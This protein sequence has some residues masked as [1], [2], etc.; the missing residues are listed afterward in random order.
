MQKVNFI[1]QL[2]LEIR[3]THHLSSL[4]ICP[5]MP[6]RTYLKQP[7]KICCFYGCVVASKNSN[8]YL[9]FLWDIVVQ[10][11]LHSDW[12]WGFWITTK[13]PEIFQTSC[14]C[15]KLKDYWQF[16]IETKKHI[17]MEKFFAKTLEVLFFGTELSKAIWTF[18]Q[19][20]GSVTFLTLCLTPWNKNQKKLMI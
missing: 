5:G 11:I 19:K 7:I 8:S 10:I 18:S 9:N 6:D 14:F 15:K 13:K 4:W 1:S 16:C 12:S 2:I 17:W 20:P 3:L